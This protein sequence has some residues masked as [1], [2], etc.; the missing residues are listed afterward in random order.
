MQ[1]ADMAQMDNNPVASRLAVGLEASICGFGLC[2]ATD[3]VW[4][5][6]RQMALAELA[7]LRQAA[8]QLFT[9]AEALPGFVETYALARTVEPGHL[10]AVM[11]SPYGLAWLRRIFDLIKARHG[12]I[13]RQAIA[14]FQAPGQDDEG[15][16]NELLD[17][18]GLLVVGA[19]V[20][21][22][23]SYEF[24]RPLRLQR[25]TT[26]PTTN[27]HV[28]PEPGGGWITAVVEGQA[29][30]QNAVLM[31]LDAVSV[32][33]RAVI[34]DPFDDFL[35]REASEGA[36]RE[37]GRASA[38]AFYDSFQDAI[39]CFATRCPEVLEE[40]ALVYH[41]IS[42]SLLAS[43]SG[44][45][46]GTTSSSLGF[47]CFSLV[48]DPLVLCEMLVHELS[49]AHLFAY[50]D[51]DPLLDPRVHGEGWAPQNLYSPW[52]DDARALNGV[53][54]AAFVFTRVANMWLRFVEA[55]PQ[56]CDLGLRRLAVL[57]YQLLV[58]RGIIAAHATWTPVGKRF[59][60]DLTARIEQIDQICR[61][62]NLVDIEPTY[63]EV[64]STGRSSGSA[65]ER[66]TAHLAR[67]RARYPELCPEAE[68]LLFA[69]ARR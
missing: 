15:Y 32:P 28:V 6:V 19:Q 33:D 51:V 69:A 48:P 21:Q 50:Q 54:H 17:R 43:P 66:Q 13:P 1:F 23:I 31:Q 42:P 57:R 65:L 38:R 35:F 26:I 63:T 45:P 68:A 11:G 39:R 41:A 14:R 44:F 37:V 20:N 22:R 9:T 60:T 55:S 34:I 18:F 49:H 12:E 46:S 24:D 8:D 40:I 59:F 16:L 62:L 27:L 58:A 53:L 5:H 52:R 64:A 29:I 30:V 4:R 2:A 61:Q 36:S 7:A 3:A 56:G 25:P 47:S 67:W 10:A